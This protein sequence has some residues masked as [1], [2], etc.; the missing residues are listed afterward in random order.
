VA[1]V[2]ELGRHAPRFSSRGRPAID[3]L[4]AHAM[5][6]RVQSV[7]VDNRSGGRDA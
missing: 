6:F 7:T 4:V 1:L 2:I 3:S 5:P